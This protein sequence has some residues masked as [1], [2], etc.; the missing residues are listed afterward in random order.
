MDSLP[1]HLRRLDKMLLD[2]ADDS[3]AMLLSELD[4]FLAGVI[5]SPEPVPPSEW[6]NAVWGGENADGMSP[7][8]N[9]TDVEALVGLVMRHY[10]DIVRAL[11]RRGQ[12]SP[13]FEVDTRHDETLWE[14]WIDGFARAVQLRLEG[15]NRILES[16]DEDAVLAY[17]GLRLL[18]EV[19]QGT[20]DI[21]EREVDA[22]DHDAENLIPIWLDILHV[23]RRH[24][25]AGGLATSSAPLLKTKVGRNEPCLCGSGKKYK[26][27]CGL[28]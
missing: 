13:I 9:I 18:N 12:Y 2:L 28:N 15:W 22:L 27:C 4:G 19:N 20:A 11:A 16:D 26:K 8:G 6:L 10:N 17:S 3:E 24:H 14:M 25:D 7:F 23:W 5:V 1:A 21:S